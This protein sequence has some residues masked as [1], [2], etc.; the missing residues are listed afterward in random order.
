MAAGPPGSLPS[1]QNG[2]LLGSQGVSGYKW[3]QSYGGILSLNPVGNNVGIGRTDASYTLHMASGAHVTTGGIWTN[4][5]S[6]QLK[7][8]FAAI[9]RTAL[10]EVL[11][12]LPITT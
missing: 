1:D 5:S 2:L 4:A 3:L 6:R 9:D 7:A 11:A 10:L 12:D 8:D